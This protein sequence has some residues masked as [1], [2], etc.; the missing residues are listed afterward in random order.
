MHRHD[1]LGH[2]G[3]ELEPCTPHTWPGQA[4]HSSK[5]AL[6]KSP[7]RKTCFESYPG[8]LTSVLSLHLKLGLETI[9]NWDPKSLLNGDEELQVDT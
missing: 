3:P 6:T 8:R 9:K 4:A 7:G 5:G 1:S 2:G